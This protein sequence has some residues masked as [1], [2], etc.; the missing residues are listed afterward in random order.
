MPQPRDRLGAEFHAIVDEIYGILTA[1]ITAT[2]GMQGQ[3][4][5]ALV[6]FLPPVSTNRLGGF[7]EALAAAPYDGHA[8]MAK[9]AA[10]LGLEINDLLPIAEALQRLEFA[11]LK[12]ATESS[13]SCRII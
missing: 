10:S 13:S 12:G 3:A 6:Q 8:A 9:I 1:R 11:D 5:G 4:H 7:I 2:A